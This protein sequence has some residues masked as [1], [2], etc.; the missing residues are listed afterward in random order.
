[1]IL[2]T[3]VCLHFGFFCCFF[4]LFKV[5]CNIQVY[6]MCKQYI[7]R[8]YSPIPMCENISGI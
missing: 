3:I 2:T 6:C 7:K 8:T 5:A 4:F 1:M